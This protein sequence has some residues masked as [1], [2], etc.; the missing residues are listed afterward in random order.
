MRVKKAGGRIFGAELTTAEK[1]AMEIEIN[2]QL[3]EA[4]RRYT[5]DIDAVILYTLHEHL[6][7]GAVRLRRFYEAFVLE[8]DKLVKHY[9]MPDE[10]PW[11]CREMLKRIGVDIEKWNDQSGRL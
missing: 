4:D 6:G 7:F 9:E 1:K 5:D 10:Y 3:V 2:R 11:L 8:H